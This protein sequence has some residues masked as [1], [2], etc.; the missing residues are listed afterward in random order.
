MG[1]MYVDRDLTFY[2]TAGGEFKRLVG[3]TVEAGE[4]G[5]NGENRKK[6]WRVTYS[7]GL[8]RYVSMSSFSTVETAFTAATLQEDVDNVALRLM[9]DL[10]IPYS[11]PKIVRGMAADTVAA[12]FEVCSLQIIKL[13]QRQLG[14]TYFP[15]KHFD[16]PTPTA[17]GELV[18]HPVIRA[19]VGLAEV[20]KRPEE[21]R[22]YCGIILAN[23][24][25]PTVTEALEQHDKALSWRWE[26]SNHFPLHTRIWGGVDFGSRYLHLEFAHLGYSM[27][28]E[29]RFAWFVHTS[30]GIFVLRILNPACDTH[31]EAIRA[32]QNW[33]YRR[34]EQD[35]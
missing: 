16:A 14:L 18:A 12:A 6:V 11:P 34:V 2:P 32:A 26:Y 31:D 29:K 4:V 8:S 10:E 30:Q 27:G 28:E 5:A 13:V 7:N 19:A 17:I 3:G 15:Q 22:R 20:L 23:E 9:N 1:Y 21:V 24:M 33:Y 25:A 35:R